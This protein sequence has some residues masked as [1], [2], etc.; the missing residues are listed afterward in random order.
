M[1]SRLT[2]HQIIAILK[3]VEAVRAMDIYLEV[4]ISD[5]RSQL[6]QLKT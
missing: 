4:A 3:S 6:L 1:R 2:E 5:S